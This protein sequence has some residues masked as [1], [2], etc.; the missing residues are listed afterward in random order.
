MFTELGFASRSKSLGTAAPAGR[1]FV[2]D[3][4][5]QLCSESAT[6][7]REVP[8]PTQKSALQTR[9]SEGFF[10]GGGNGGFFQG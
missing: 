5:D 7:R 8:W 6:A 10:P 4:A 1:V 3:F 9:A 2:S